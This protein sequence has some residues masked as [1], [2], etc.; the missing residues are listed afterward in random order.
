M[1][2][3]FFFFFMFFFFF[4]LGVFPSSTGFVL[5]VLFAF[6]FLFIRRLCIVDFVTLKWAPPFRDD[7]IV[8]RPAERPRRLLFSSPSPRHSLS[9]IPHLLNT[10]ISS[11]TT[12]TTTIHTHVSQ[13]F[14]PPSHTR[15]KNFATLISHPNRCRRSKTTWRLL[16]IPGSIVR[17]NRIEGQSLGVVGSAA[18]LEV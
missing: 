10:H 5:I 9:S 8:P 17:E 18:L 3:F 6:V 1:D 2:S 4:L 7:A 11:T 15:S 14:S 16:S 12:T 13:S